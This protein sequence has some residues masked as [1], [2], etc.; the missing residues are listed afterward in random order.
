MATVAQ[1]VQQMLDRQQV[2]A[3]KL[4]SDIGQADKPTRVLNM[5]LLAM[6]GTVIKALVDDPAATVTDADL[7]TIFNAARDGEWPDEPIDPPPD[8]V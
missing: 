4:G 1:Y 3:R 7:I 2:I 6:L 5:A 8:G